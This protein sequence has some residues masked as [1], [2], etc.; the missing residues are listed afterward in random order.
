MNIW[1]MCLEK[2]C[3]DFHPILEL[4][5]VKWEKKALDI[6]EWPSWR[7]QPGHQPQGAQKEA[8]FRR[9]GDEHCI[10]SCLLQY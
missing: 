9:R 5:T 7:R 4:C 10:P 6:E 1:H 8:G 3:L 2:S